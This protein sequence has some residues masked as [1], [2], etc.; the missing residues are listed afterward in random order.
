[1]QKK[2]FLSKTF[3][4]VRSI[5][6]DIIINVHRSSHNVPAI[7]VRFNKNLKFLDGFSKNANTKFYENPLSGSRVFPCGRINSQIGRRNEINIRFSKFS[8]AHKF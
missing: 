3:L 2:A 7:L 1:V 4:I 5:E 8:N 6:R